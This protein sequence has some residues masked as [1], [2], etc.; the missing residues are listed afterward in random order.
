M[1]MINV[2][3]VGCREL[4]EPI[5]KALNGKTY[6]DFQVRLCP[7]GGSFDVN[8][9]TLN[10]DVTEQELVEMVLFVLTS[11]LQKRG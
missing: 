3:N 11:D 6:M 9:E 4:A 2:N 10:P 1:V 5:E 7:I 8:V